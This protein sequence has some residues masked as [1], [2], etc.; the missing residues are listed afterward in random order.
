MKPPGPLPGE[1]WFNTVYPHSI[2]YLPASLRCGPGG[3]RWPQHNDAGTEILDS[4]N[5]ALGISLYLWL[6]GMS[7]AVSNHLVAKYIY[8]LWS[9]MVKRTTA[10]LFKSGPY[11]LN[12]R[13]LNIFHN[14]AFPVKVYI[15]NK[16]DLTWDVLDLQALGL[17]KKVLGNHIDKKVDRDNIF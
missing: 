2:R 14:N 8:L 4:V 1:R 9:S 16:T 5:E 6:I 15:V 13:S 10:L 3:P 17:T 7:A 12:D 11:I